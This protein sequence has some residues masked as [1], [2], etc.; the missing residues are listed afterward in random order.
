MIAAARLKTFRRYSRLIRIS[1]AV[2]VGN[3]FRRRVIARHPAALY[4]EH[5]T[6]PHV[7]VPRTKLALAFEK[8]G[9][10]VVRRKV[11]HP[12]H[13]AYRIMTTARRRA[14]RRIV[15]VLKKYRGKIRLE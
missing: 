7:I 1:R 14:R 15:D 12:G 8:E 3:V 11:F 9:R 6:R 4:L 13:R 10:L 2:R 5:G